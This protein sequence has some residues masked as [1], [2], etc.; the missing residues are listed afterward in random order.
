MRIAARNQMEQ[1]SSR[2]N[3][4]LR[5]FPAFLLFALQDCEDRGP[6][7]VSSRREPPARVPNQIRVA[8]HFTHA[9]DG[10]IRGPGTELLVPL[11]SY[12]QSE[13]AQFLSFRP[14]SQSRFGDG[15]RF[16]LKYRMN[17]LEQRDSVFDTLRDVR[18]SPL[19]KRENL[20]QSAT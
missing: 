8:K 16:F 18:W 7:L 17:S 12:E 4:S 20:L 13:R 11:L 3:N 1:L 10:A 14:S 15:Q 5:S 9:G 2:S 6:S 19:E